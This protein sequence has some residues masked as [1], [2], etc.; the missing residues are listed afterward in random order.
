MDE[1]GHCF[2]CG[3][4]V[5]A[6]APY[7]LCPECLNRSVVFSNWEGGTRPGVAL[8]S[9]QNKTALQEGLS[10]GGGRFKLVRELGRGGMGVVWL[11]A[12]QRLK[13]GNAAA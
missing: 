12:D 3:K 4:D 8:S 11:A 7:G 1:H 2:S 6:D 5:A 9:D 10:V 13:D